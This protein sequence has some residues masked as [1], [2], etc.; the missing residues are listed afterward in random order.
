M[1]PTV[2]FPSFAPALAGRS[3]S[4]R[5]ASG[6]AASPEPHPRSPKSP[7]P[8]I[9]NGGITV[10]H[11]W[12]LWPLPD[13]ARQ[14]HFGTLSLHRPVCL[15]HPVLS[16]SRHAHAPRAGLS[17]HR[18]SCRQN[19]HIRNVLSLPSV[20]YLTSRTKDL[21]VQ[22][23]AHT[24]LRPK[25]QRTEPLHAI[26]VPQSPNPFDTIRGSPAIECH[27]ST[28]RPSSTPGPMV[29]DHSTGN[30]GRDGTASTPPWPPKARL[31][32]ARNPA[33]EALATALLT[34]ITSER[35]V[36][37]IRHANMSRL[38]SPPISR[39]CIPHRASI[40]HFRQTATSDDTDSAKRIDAV[41]RTRCISLSHL[42]KTQGR[43]TDKA[44]Q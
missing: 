29:G 7:E 31:H 9:G 20:S 36:S 21:G 23:Y 18:I 4:S 13:A 14:V 41:G 2:E 44:R 39:P 25:H 27:R 40:I 33:N 43:T 34:T 30:K 15:P 35:V 32:R 28:T 42:P 22:H 12:W 8:P 16:T 19:G 10:H 17:G 37:P 24:C 5:L 1:P 11:W 38:F 3:F 6:I 26:G